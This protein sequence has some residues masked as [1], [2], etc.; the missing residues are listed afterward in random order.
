MLVVSLLSSNIMFNVLVCRFFVLAFVNHILHH[1]THPIDTYR[2]SMVSV[3]Q[4]EFHMSS[5]R[6]RGAVMKQIR[7]FVLHFV[8]IDHG[9]N[10]IVQMDFL[11][12]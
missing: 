9:L 7:F 5:Y 8:G 4:H 6:R 10:A 11:Y 1:E 12:V 2:L 3:R